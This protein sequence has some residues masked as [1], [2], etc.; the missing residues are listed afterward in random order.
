MWFKVRGAVLFLIL[1]GGV[2]GATSAQQSVRKHE[3]PDAVARKNA[4]QRQGP[5]VAPLL[6]PD[7]GLAVLAAALQAHAQADLMRDCSHLVNGIYARAGFPYPYVQSSNLY[8]GTRE[9]WRVVRPQPGDLV[10]WPGHVGIVINPVQHS[11]YSALRSGF[12]VADYDSTYWRRR[13]QARFYRYIKGFSIT[14]R[15]TNEQS[16]SLTV[17]G[18]QVD[19]EQTP[20]PLPSTEKSKVA[21]ALSKAGPVMPADMLS[22]QVLITDPDQPRPE[23]VRE[24]L[25]RAFREA[26]KALDGSDVLQ[27]SRTLVVF[28]ELE[29]AKLHVKNKFGWVEVRIGESSSLTGGQ[30]DLKRH[31]TQHRWLIRRRNDEDVWEIALPNDTVYVP[32][33]AAVR[34]L[35]NQLAVLMREAGEPASG[36]GKTVLLARVLNVLLEESLSGS[37]PHQITKSAQQAR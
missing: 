4:N 23:V 32:R 2:S 20:A 34:D 15:T 19:P 17:S 10:V 37:P 18:S 13:G 29:V 31:S 24:A 35:A 21:A 11:F 9:F 3:D 7:D 16:A 28:D 5:F 36:D 6:S 1:W 25:I 14:D 33:D 26:G 8:T 30:A 27:L 12:G 22:P